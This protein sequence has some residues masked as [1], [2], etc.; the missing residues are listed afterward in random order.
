MDPIRVK[1]VSAVA[2]GDEVQLQL[3]FDET[4]STHLYIISRR[5]ADE[6]RAHITAII[7]ESR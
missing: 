7:G 1:D 2:V 4:S 3:R 6:L 5:Q